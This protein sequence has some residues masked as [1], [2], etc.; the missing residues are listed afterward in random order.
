LLRSANSLERLFSEISLFYFI[1]FII[2]LT[3]LHDNS[4]GA[5]IT[6]NAH[7]KSMFLG[8]R[9]L[10]GVYISLVYCFPV[11]DEL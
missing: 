9:F 5:I 2:V 11:A 3:F 10:T 1:H 6:A 8:G 4:V 7:N